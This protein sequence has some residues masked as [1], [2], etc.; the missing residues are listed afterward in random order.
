MGK[1]AIARAGMT[2]RQFFGFAWLATLGGLIGQAGI[3]LLSFLKPT[4]PEG[5]F[6]GQVVAGELAEFPAGSVSYILRGR[7]YIVRLE[8]GGVLALWQRCTHLGCTVPWREEQGQFNCPCHSSLF[9]RRGEVIG[10][11]APRPLDY[12]PVLLEEGKLVI[13][14]GKP[15]QRKQF[16]A[17]QVFYPGD[18]PQ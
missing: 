2:R 8:D 12:F 5:D 9:T 1:R 7:C 17:S 13:D 11:P 16:D 10:G 3:A 6:G 18:R 4:E 14:T 15:T